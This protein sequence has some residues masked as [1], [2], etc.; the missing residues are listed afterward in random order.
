MNKVNQINEIINTDLHIVKE[1]LFDVDVMEAILLDKNTFSKSNLERLSAYYRS[2]KHGNSVEVIYHYGKGCEKNQLG[3]LYVRNNKGLQSFPFDIRNPLLEKHYW[4]IDGENMHYNLLLKIA[5][6]WNIEINNIKYY[7]DNRNECLNK[8]SS[9]R[10]IAKTAFIKVA[11]GGNIKLYNEHYNDDNI[12][13]DGDISLLKLIEKEINILMNE[14]YLLYPQYHK[15][16]S[17]KPNPKSSLFAYILQTEERKCILALDNYF[18]SVNR[19]VDIIIHDGV[20]VRKLPDETSFPDNLLL[21]GENAI[22]E[23]TGHKIK[24]VCK[25]YQHNFKFNKT[26]KIIIDDIYAAKKFIELMDNNIVRDK[27]DIYYFNNTNGLWENNDS[28]FRIAVN[29]HKNNLIFFDQI[30]NKY[31]NYGGIEKNVQSMK[32]WILSLLTDNEFISKNSDSSIGKLL[33]SDGYYDFFTNQFIPEFNQNIVFFKRINRPFPKDRNEDLIKFVSD[34]LFINAFND[35]DSLEAG[36]FLK[37]Y[38]CIGLIG[39]YFRKKFIFATG[40]ANCGKGVLVNAFRNSFDGYID[41]Y[42]A[43]NLLY[44]PLNSQDEAKKLSWIK[45]LLGVRIAFS[46]ECR[47]SDNRGIDGNLL[48]TLASGS[49]IMK[50]RSNYE[51]QNNFINRSTMFMLSNDCPNIT[52]IDTGVCE[53]AKFIRYKL[54]FVNNPVSSDEKLADPTIKIKFQSDD[55]KN[56]LLFVMIDTFNSM[57]FDEKKI[58]G[59]IYEPKS[60]IQETKQWI[61]DEKSVFLDKLNEKFEITNNPNDYVETRKI[62]EYLIETC[63]LNMSATK[64]GIILSKLTTIEPKDK[65]I[66]NKRCRLG[67]KF[68]SNNIDIDI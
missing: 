35:N 36:V 44:N 56:A 12:H 15:L 16:V 27:N 53:R 11:Y 6:D 68:N 14:C 64:I 40:D 32:K 47:I 22:Y 41:E 60:V 23:S 31:I 57:T 25:P 19:Q 20:E 29:K 5:N 50:I 1:E 9:D 63:K 42:D 28:A 21:G 38:L 8:L 2:R 43:N 18:K 24:L 61:K 37:K 48:K 66:K 3:R 67:I 49:D 54:R 59:Y 34:T 4:D 39:D 30:S 65:N 33:F 45:D 58:G 52:P 13:P 51:S 10:K 55:Y 7:C 62:I 26:P 46:N 17:K